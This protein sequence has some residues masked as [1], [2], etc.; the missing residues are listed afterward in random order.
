MP[1]L[2]RLTTGE[3][4]TTTAV[5]WLLHMRD[6][7]ILEPTV[8]AEL[9]SLLQDCHAETESRADAERTA[10]SNAMAARRNRA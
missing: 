5:A 1:D 4:T 7:G 6:R 8:A 2:G 10:R 3:L 9:S